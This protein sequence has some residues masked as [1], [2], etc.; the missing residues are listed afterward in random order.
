MIIKYTGDKPVKMVEVGGKH[1]KFDPVCQFNEIFDLPII[2]WLLHPDRA[3][4]FVVSDIKD[5]TP[6]VSHPEMT[7]VMKEPVPIIQEG[8]NMARHRGR[9]R[10]V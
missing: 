1:F 10:K 8:K 6:S 4:L 7:N 9:P 2:E 3:G 5:K